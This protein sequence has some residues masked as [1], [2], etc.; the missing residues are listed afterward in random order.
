MFLIDRTGQLFARN[1]K[2]QF[3]TKPSHCYAVS[4]TS[5]DRLG[6]N[7]DYP[8]RDFFKPARNFENDVGE[9]VKS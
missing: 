4:L 2:E 8:L 1:I 6:T 3:E 9:V 7:S 5:N